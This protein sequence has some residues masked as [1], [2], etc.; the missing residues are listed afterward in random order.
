MACRNGKT[1]EQV[2]PL[3]GIEIL[4]DPRNSV[5]D[6]DPDPPTWRGGSGENTVRCSYG[7]RIYP[8]VSQ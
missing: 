3:F 8:A 4:E 7:I 2:E 1:G 6:E 5:L